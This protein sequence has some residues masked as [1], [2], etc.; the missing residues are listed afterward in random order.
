MLQTGP[1][2]TGVILLLMLVSWFQV[3]HEFDHIFTGKTLRLDYFHSGTA[4]QE[5]FSVDQYRIEGDWP[6]SKTHLVD[7]TNLGKFLFQVIDVASNRVIYSRGFCSIYI[8]L[9]LLIYNL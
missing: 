2:A 9:N 6:G 3:P 4:E 7:D 8:L 1:F 5:E